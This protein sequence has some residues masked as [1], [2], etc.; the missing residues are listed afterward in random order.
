MKLLSTSGLLF[1]VA[2]ASDMNGNSGAYV[3]IDWAAVFVEA[4][5]LEGSTST[6]AFMNTSGNTNTIGLNP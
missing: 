5:L 3:M 2:S 6:G 1:A 4:H